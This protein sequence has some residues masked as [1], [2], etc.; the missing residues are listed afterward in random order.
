MQRK[1]PNLFFLKS[2]LITN[3]KI[4]YFQNSFLHPLTILGVWDYLLVYIFAYFLQKNVPYW[5]PH[6]LATFQWQT[7]F[8]SQ[9]IK[10]YVFLNSC[11]ANW[12]RQKLYDLSWII[13][14]SNIWQVKKEGKCEIQKF[15]YL[16]K[17]NLFSLNKKHFS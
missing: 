8:P 4:S 10:Q 3:L 6:Q 7:Y 17:K 5:K 11:L 9:D 15:K 14:S 1:D 12:W 13:L 2:F 16:E